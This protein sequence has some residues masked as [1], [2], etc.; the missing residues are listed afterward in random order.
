MNTLIFPSERRT[1]SECISEKVAEAKKMG[2]RN[3]EVRF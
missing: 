3:E 1:N 2:L